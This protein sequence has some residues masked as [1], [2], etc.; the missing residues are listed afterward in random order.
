MSAA[1]LRTLAQAGALR[2]IDL[3][4]AQLLARLDASR[5]DAVALAGA[6]ASAAVGHGHS[7]VRLAR[8]GELFAAGGADPS[9][10]ELPDAARLG[11]ALAASPLVAAPDESR[12]TP[13][14]LG[15]D[16]RLWLRRYYEYE[17]RVAAGLRARA[18]AIEPVDLA[19]LRGNLSR[20]L[21]MSAAVDW[22]AVAIALG[23]RSRLAIV[24]GGPG[25]GKTTTVLWL[26]A[27]LLADAHA[28]GRPPPRIR[29][30][31]PTGKAAA[32]LGEA[33]RERKR[34]LGLDAAL[35]ESIRD[36]EAATVHRLLGYSP[37][38]GFRY[39]ADAPLDADVVVVD[40]ASMI[41][42]PLVA[43][44]V[45][46]LRADARLIL[47][48]DVGQLA[49]VEAGHVLAAIAPDDAHVNRY[50]P[51]TAAWLRDATGFAVP[52][53]DG[54]QTPLGDAFV[55]LRE[56]RRFADAGGIGRLARAVRAGDADAALAELA[57]GAAELDWQREGAAA[58][59]DALAQR[60]SPEFRRI[61]DCTDAAGAL[62]AAARLRILTA[63]RDGAS[64]CVTINRALEHALGDGAAWY[65]GRLVMI[66]ANDYR[67]ALF[68]GD[69]GVAWP[70]ADGTLA[71]W[72]AG[73]D[74]A[75]RRFAPYTL[76]AHEPAFAMTVHKSQGSEFDEVAIVLPAAPSRVLGRELLYTAVTRA[77]SRVRVWGDEGVIRATVARRIERWSGLPELLRA[78]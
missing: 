37:A 74:G 36:D 19:V 44:L 48:G 29:L 52:L 53:V 12:A 66:A 22:Q 42:L 78:P 1:L 75:L 59:A 67:H 77:R 13:L 64:G 10:L 26:L 57:G 8:L 41:D 49:S 23:L 68:N 38:R 3:E 63:L 55:E 28:R 50:A 9:A 7:S 25:T 60:Y 61:A 71:V 34:T 56:S 54:A 2:E 17:R 5:A 30:A 4:L 72:F 47:L 32:R 58:S 76:P 14:V 11:A 45:D 40:E 31:A 73:E 20:W 62:A 39:G 6:A 15:A 43:R 24:A 35:A 21:A 65:R 33:V 18:A 46:A 51:A 69:V 27:A 16:G 70:D